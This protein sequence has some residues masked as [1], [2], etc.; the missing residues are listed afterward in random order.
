VTIAPAAAYRSWMRALLIL[1][2]CAVV[3]APPATGESSSTSLVI[4]YLEDAA[5]PDDRV[6][7]TLRCEPT[8]GSHPRRAAACRELG[9]LGWR[10]FRAVPTDMACTELYGGPQRAIVSGRID[11]R[12]VW[13]KLTRVDG[14]QIARWDRVP[15]L[16]PAGGVR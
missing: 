9:R 3:L 15:S 4:T 10:A 14:C 6:R 16:L 8:G 11:G 7:W 12:R 5:M 1:A 13:A 2:C